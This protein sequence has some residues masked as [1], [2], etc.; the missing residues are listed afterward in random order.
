MLTGPEFSC[1]KDST[2]EKRE[3]LILLR[4]KNEQ[5]SEGDNRDVD[6]LVEAMKYPIIVTLQDWRYPNEA[7]EGV[8]VLFTLNINIEK[9]DKFIKVV[10]QELSKKTIKGYH[11]LESK[12]K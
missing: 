12:V 6:Q 1:Q 10:L 9:I 5:C 3:E 4:K 8:M 2:I 7:F 11:K